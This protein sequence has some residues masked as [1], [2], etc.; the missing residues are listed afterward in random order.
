M[1]AGLGA[2]AAITGLFQRSMTGRGTHADVSMTATMLSVNGR[3]HMEANGLGPLGEPAALSA[4]ESP[5]F[6]MA[7]GS[8]ITVAAG[9]RSGSP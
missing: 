2:L 5:V 6:E 9:G 4:P 7:D 3:L 8:L 1:P